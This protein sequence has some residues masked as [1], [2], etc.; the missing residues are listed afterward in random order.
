MKNVYNVKNIA[1]VGGGTSAWLAAAFLSNQRPDYTITVIDKEVGSPVGVGEGTL[2]GF[3]QIMEQCGFKPEDWFFEIDATFKSGILFPEWGKDNSDVWH[4]FSFPMHHNLGVS[5]I[6]IWSARQDLDFKTHGLS[7][8]DVSVNHNK[9]DVEVLQHGNYA[10]H[11]DCSKLVNLIQQKILST[12]NVTSI[13]SEVVEIVRDANRIQTLVLKN[14][15]TI[16][17]DLYIDCTGFKHLLHDCPDRVTVEG[18]LFC[19]TAIAGHVPY[20]D[21][22][23]EMLPYVKSSAV[24]HGWIWN[25]PVQSRIGSGLVFN[26]N[27]TDIEEA[28]DFFVNYW[29][30]RI[31]KDQLKVIDWTPF[32]NKNMWHGNVVS[33]GLSAGFIEP[34]ESTG[35]A[36]I[37]T[38]LEQMVF[39]LGIDYYTEQDVEIYNH[40]MIGYFEDCID[41]VGMHYSNIDK[42]SKFWK[43]VKDTRVISS[44]Q[45]QFENDMISDKEKLSVGSQGFVFSGTNWIC[46][47]IQMG[48]PLGKKTNLAADQLSQLISSHADTELNKTNDSIP[49]IEYLE[50]LKQRI[51]NG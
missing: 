29:D 4:P 32:Y 16:S 22:D 51:A 11:I 28:K 26:R 36:L 14:K 24:E 3:G 37:I 6:D 13:K 45:K 5:S 31:S 42:D 12:R 23:T 1:I 15:Q 17:A 50:I 33:I 41:F 40:T 8:Y 49:H 47:L 10:Y 48:L 18:R 39:R 25:I 27:I 21:K 2:L 46:W 35:V 43:W 19:D 9:V 7:M 20:K 38:G 44:R 30:N 34:L